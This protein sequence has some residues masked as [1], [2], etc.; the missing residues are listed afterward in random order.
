MRYSKL[1]LTELS[2]GIKETKTAIERGKA[3]MKALSSNSR[4]KGLRKVADSASKLIQ[5]LEREAVKLDK[6]NEKLTA[7]EARKART[8]NPRAAADDGA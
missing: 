2:D 3:F 8:G 4:V 7:R 6:A 1:S 5:K